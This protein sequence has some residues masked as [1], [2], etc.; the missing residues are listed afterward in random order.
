VAAGP[1]VAGTREFN[2][3]VQSGKIVLLSGE[4]PEGTMVKVRVK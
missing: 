1:A 2:G 4:L 3:I